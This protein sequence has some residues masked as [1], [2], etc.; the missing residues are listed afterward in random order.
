VTERTQRT[1]R[2]SGPFTDDDIVAFIALLRRIDDANPTGLYRATFVDPDA[3]AD[4]AE[5]RLHALVPLTPFRDTTFARAAYHD[6]SYPERACD[7][8]GKPYRGPAVYCSF[9]CAVADA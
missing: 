6:D 8:C 7:H 1:L 9:A 4:E 3:S 5:A 2:I